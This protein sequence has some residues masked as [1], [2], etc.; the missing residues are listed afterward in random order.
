MNKH[1][2]GAAMVA[3]IAFVSGPASAHFRLEAPA[4]TL[5]QDNT[6]NPQKIAP[7]GGTSKDAGK[8]SGAM[9]TLK[10]G[11]SLHFKMTETVFHP[12]HYRI[13][14]A[15]T[16]D[17]LPKDPPTVTRE[18]PRGP[19]SVRAMIDPAPQP[20]MWADGL[21]PHTQKPATMPMTWETDLKVPNVDCAQCVV[22]V[23]QWMGE[24]GFNPDG[25]YSYHHCAAVKIVRDP[26]LPVDRA[27]T[28]LLAAR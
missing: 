27:W 19:M 7:C 16:P 8:P 21:F 4:A 5:D 18:G 3:A 9:T 26:K 22:Q 28:R 15:R 24:H 11:Q 12:G 1:F 25:E 13:A 23:V 2:V 6:G 17:L 10:G 20:P 14:L